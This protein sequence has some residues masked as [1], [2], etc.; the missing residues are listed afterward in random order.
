MSCQRIRQ[1][2]RFG[3][4]K[5]SNPPTSQTPPT[6]HRTKHH[7]KFNTMLM[8]LIMMALWGMSEASNCTTWRKMRRGSCYKVCGEPMAFLDAEKYCRHENGHLTSIH[9]AK[10]KEIVFSLARRYRAGLQKLGQI[11]T[12]HIWLGLVMIDNVWKWTDQSVID[13]FEC[14]QCHAGSREKKNYC[15]YMETS[16]RVHRHMWY[17]KLCMEKSAFVCKKDKC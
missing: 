5:R 2:S 4:V 10:E 1:P 12:P 17:R 13:Y 7:Y 11:V 16:R 14:P 9:N 8:L 3:E 6:F 15:A